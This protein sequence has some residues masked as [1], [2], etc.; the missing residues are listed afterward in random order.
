MMTRRS[1]GPDWRRMVFWASLVAALSVLPHLGV[2]QGRDGAPAEEGAAAQSYFR[3]GQTL[4]DEGRFVDAGAEFDRAY[5]LAK[6]P[7]L[8]YNAYLA[9]R[10]AGMLD[11]AADRLRRYIE[12]GDDAGNRAVLQSRLASLE[13]QIAERDAARAAAEEQERLLHEEAENDERAAQEETAREQLEAERERADRAQ[14]LAIGVGGVGGAALIAGAI[15]GGV[16]LGQANSARE[17]C[18]DGLCPFGFDLAQAQADVFGLALASDIL[19]GLGAAAMVTGL[20]IWLVT[21]PSSTPESEAPAVQA[22]G[23]CL[24]HGCTASLGVRF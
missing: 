23:V 7:L 16:A 21:R 12:T 6:R 24:A 17:A 11:E 15:F 18:P 3:V 19:V 1:V 2:A 5:D 13:A 22:S 8:L 14:G 9:Y 10:D 20:V 4:Y